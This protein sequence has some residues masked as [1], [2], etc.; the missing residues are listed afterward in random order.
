MPQIFSYLVGIVLLILAAGGYYA[1][2]TSNVPASAIDEQVI[3]EATS[4]PTTQKIESA[5]ATIPKKTEAPK[6][7][8]TQKIPS[9]PTEMNPVSMPPQPSS[10]VAPSVP[11][12]QVPVPEP[13]V[14]PAPTSISVVIQN[15][16]FSPSQLTVKKGTTVTWTN[17]DAIGH[18]VTPDNGSE[19]SS[20]IL[21]Q[22]QSYSHIFETLGTYSYHCSPHPN[23]R[24][25]VTVTE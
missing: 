2:H 15:F 13:V 14:P 6:S 18:S 22:G 11:P 5:A 20:G 4:T 25:S 19:I 7:T 12:Q 9:P 3:T 16:D 24:G 1:T 10:T 21:Q 8:V 23:M 17:N